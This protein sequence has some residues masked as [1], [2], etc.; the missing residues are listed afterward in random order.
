[1]KN[2][3]G[4]ACSI[5]ALVLSACGGSGGGGGGSSTPAV[6]IDPNLT[7]PIKTAVANL[8]NNGINQNFTVT[9]WVNNSTLANPVPNTPITGSG[10]LTIGPP[11]SAT[12]NGASVLESTEV[13]IGS[14]SA[15]GQSIPVA[16][17]SNIFYNPSNYTKVGSVTNGVTTFI[18]PYTYPTSVKAGSTGT[19]GSGTSSLSTILTSYTVASDT[20]SSLLVTLVSTKNTGVGY[21]ATV[22]DQTVYRITTSGAISLVS[23]NVQQSLNGSVYQSLTFTF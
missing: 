15:N 23:E 11:I 6:V 8:V 2:F 12:F 5:F 9:G 21:T 10:T 22:Q 1:M 17:T 18:S 7:V 16:A 19:L 13:I 4:L 14:A 20:A 3:K